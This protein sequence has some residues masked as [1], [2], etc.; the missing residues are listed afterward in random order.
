MTSA[1]R[2]TRDITPIGAGARRVSVVIPVMERPVELAAL[3]REFSAAMQRAGW[4]IECVFVIP[5]RF[6]AMGATVTELAAQGEPVQLLSLAQDVEP[7]AMV[8][9]GVQAA[10]SELILLLPPYPRVVAEAVPDL[11]RRVEGGADLVAAR[12]WPRRD[13][14]VNR[15]QNRIFHRLV[16]GM[17]GRQLH[18]L[19][20]GVIATRRRVL[21]QVAPYGDFLR[22][23]PILAAREAFVVEEMDAPQ[24]PSDTAGRVHSPGVYVRRLLDLLALFFLTRFTD[25][26]LRFFGAIGAGF[27]LVG[28]LLLFVLFVQR[29]Q[30]AGIA[31]RPLLLLGLLLFVVGV[32]IIALGLVAEII[33]FLQSSGRRNYRLMSEVQADRRGT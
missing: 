8:G 15:A 27:G 29:L 19:G 28:G 6:A 26:P 33:V 3:Y 31:N 24:H 11:L 10:T 16:G 18:D 20:C 22:F 12:R 25:K 14:W 30:G 7:A 1:E 5:P 2:L 32:Q 17:A 23:L 9:A 13:P 21:I 4:A